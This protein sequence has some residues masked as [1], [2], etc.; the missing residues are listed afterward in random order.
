MTQ[1]FQAAC[2][3]NARQIA[4]GAFGTSNGLRAPL[5]VSF[6]ATG[7]SSIQMPLGHGH[8]ARFSTRPV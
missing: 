8:L 1:L 5:C 3:A 6:D 2:A 7:S 4:G